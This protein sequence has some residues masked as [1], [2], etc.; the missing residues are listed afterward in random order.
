[1]SRVYVTAYHCATEPSGGIVR[2]AGKAEVQLYDH[3]LTGPDRNKAATPDLEGVTAIA[4]GVEFYFDV[5]PGNYH[6][7]INFPNEFACNANGP[8]LVLPGTERHLYTSGLH[9][10]T[11]WHGTL[12]IAGRVD[13]QG[14]TVHAAFLERQ[15]KCGDDSRYFNRRYE[16]G[17]M[18]AGFYYANLPSDNPVD[19]NVV[20]ILSGAL[21]TERIVLVTQPMGGPSHR[22]D[23]VVKEITP[24]VLAAAASAPNK[25]AC[26]PGF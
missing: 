22:G 1:M 9:A 13:V 16:D 24:E 23:V 19:H 2:D 12:G 17:T 21:F 10:I 18:D 4:G 3:A 26:V 15:A 25:F 7:F 8:L 14:V 6:A 11:D 5:L 20:L